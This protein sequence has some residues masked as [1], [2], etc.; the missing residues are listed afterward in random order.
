MSQLADIDDLALFLDQDL[1]GSGEARALFM[2]TMASAAVRVYTGQQ[3]EKVED[4]AV[5]LI[6]TYADY[7]QLPQRPVLSVAS[8]AVNIPGFPAQ[9]LPGAT[10][11]VDPRGRLF[12]SPNALANGPDMEFPAGYFGGPLSTVH[13]VYTHGYDTI[14]DEVIMAT[15]MIAGRLLRPGGA[16]DGSMASETLGDYSYK[17]AAELAGKLLQE[18]R[19]LLRPY[20]Y[21]RNM[22]SVRT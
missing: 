15:C 9:A 14:P 16:V 3:I 1:S 20:C 11:Y 13:V 17:R 21:A 10:F 12:Y 6:G 7:L 18:E 19:E 4:D 22:Q 5:D 2:L 8:V